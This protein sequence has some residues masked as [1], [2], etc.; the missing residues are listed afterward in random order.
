MVEALLTTSSRAG[1]L[2]SLLLILGNEMR[3][4]RLASLYHFIHH[5][6]APA[7]LCV[8]HYM[9]SQ[10]RCLLDIPLP[11]ALSFISSSCEALVGSFFERPFFWVS[12]LS[13]SFSL[14]LRPL[15]WRAPSCSRVWRLPTPWQPWRSARMPTPRC[16]LLQSLLNIRAFRLVFPL[17]PSVPP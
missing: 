10:C 7:C 3:R 8:V 12:T 1:L 15:R 17:A 2:R 5:R 9:C 14:C 11:H 16:R 6:Y 4:W 13:H